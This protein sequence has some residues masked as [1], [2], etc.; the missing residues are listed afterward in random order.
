MRQWVGSAFHRKLGSNAATGGVV[1]RARH[2]LAG[3]L[4]FG[5]HGEPEC[6]R[7]TGHA[8]EH[9]ACRQTAK[10]RSERSESGACKRSEE[11]F[12]KVRHETGMEHQ[13]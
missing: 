5:E 1:V 8:V 2:V 3:Q 9:A 12:A 7:A 13:A 6:E 4:A 10:E 11:E